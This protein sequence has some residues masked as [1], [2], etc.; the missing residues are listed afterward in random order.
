MFTFLAYLKITIS[1]EMWGWILIIGLPL[2]LLFAIIGGI[3]NF[4]VGVKQKKLATFKMEEEENWANDAGKSFFKRLS[5]MINNNESMSL[6]QYP[7]LEG[8]A[9]LDA[10]S[11]NERFG[12]VNPKFSIRLWY[13]V[14]VLHNRYAME[15]NPLPE[16]TAEAVQQMDGI[17]LVN[18]EVLHEKFTDCSWFELRRNSQRNWDYHGLGI[19]IPLGAGM[20]Y[21]I[22]K[23]QAIQIQQKEEYNCEGSGTLY[24]TNR[25]IVFIG[26]NQN[27]VI[28]LKGILEIEQY[29]DSVVIGKS[30][31]KKPI[32]KFDGDDAA[33]F[34]RVMVKLFQTV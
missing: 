21:R 5:V 3:R 14:S 19:R 26:R 6:T 32:V 15:Q 34:S 12:I 25:R 23:M 10:E 1:N 18:D 13:C 2:V 22:G 31:G 29:L 7:E 9:N 20:S 30:Q 8:L 33:L 4:F 11:I 24:V 28:P 17:N 27:N 16:Q